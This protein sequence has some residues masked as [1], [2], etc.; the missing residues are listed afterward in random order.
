MTR[1]N[2]ISDRKKSRRLD[3]RRNRARRIMEHSFA[4]KEWIKTIRA[5]YAFWPNEDRRAHERR[6]LS[7]RILERRSFIL[8]AHRYAQFQLTPESQKL[9]REEKEMLNA[10]NDKY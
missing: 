3:E 9:T 4:S 10:L 6:G 8:E 5:T 1:I 7:R 2:P